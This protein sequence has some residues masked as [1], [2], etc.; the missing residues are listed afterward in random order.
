MEERDIDMDKE[1]NSKIQLAGIVL[2]F[3]IGLLTILATIFGPIIQ[4]RFEQ[5][6]T[7]TPIV[8]IQSATPAPVI[9][10]DTVPPGADTSTPA[11]TNTPEPAPTETSIP[12]LAA[13]EDWK[14]GCVSMV[15]QVTSNIATTDHGNGCW[16][17]PVYAFS[18]DNGELDFLS[19]RPNGGSEVYGM[20]APLP[21]SGSVSIKIRLN[22]LNNADMWVGIFQKPDITSPGMLL[23]IAAGD[24]KKRVIAWKD[25]ATY[26]TIQKTNP[27]D[28]DNGFWFTFEFDALSVVGELNPSAFVTDSASIPS[29]QKWLFIGYKGLKGY[30][31][32]EGS[33][34][35][36]V[37]K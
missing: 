23:T 10:T 25:I 14:A 9:P 6:S 18:A 30:Y 1:S 19:E 28:Q 2:T 21:E 16:E 20:F 4:K 7:Q 29:S 27:I 32:V 13:G 3:V 24:P 15:W 35:E 37:L 5:D 8:I 22:D 12:I 33:F 17:E 36:Y 31:R 34:F 26:E 11:P